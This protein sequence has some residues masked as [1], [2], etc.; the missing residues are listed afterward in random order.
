MIDSIVS[1]PVFGAQFLSPDNLT[2]L[3]R[4]DEKRIGAIEPRRYAVTECR[5]GYFHH[6]VLACF[7]T[8]RYVPNAKTHAE[9]DA[10]RNSQAKEREPRK[11]QGG[12][13]CGGAMSCIALL[14]CRTTSPDWALLEQRKYLLGALLIGRTAV[15]ELNIESL[16]LPPECAF[17]DT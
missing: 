16:H 17:I 9:T 1:R 15:G 14:Q 13:N 12:L 8:A 10:G 11:T 6:N 7:P 2:A 5:Y 4:D 3:Q